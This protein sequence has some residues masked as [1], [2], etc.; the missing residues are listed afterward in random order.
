[1]ADPT[2]AVPT[3]ADKGLKPLA[4]HDLAT[5]E[6]GDWGSEFRAEVG[7]TLRK[8]GA[9]ILREWATQSLELDRERA[10]KSA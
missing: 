2:M 3:M 6:L 8:T 9:E 7:A 5:V 10:P 1:M 4:P